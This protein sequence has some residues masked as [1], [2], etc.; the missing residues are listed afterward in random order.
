MN[1]KIAEAKSRL[2]LP[3]LMSQLGLGDHT[4]ELALEYDRRT[5]TRCGVRE[6]YNESLTMTWCE[7]CLWDLVAD[8]QE[9]L[10]P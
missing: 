9:E 6:V 1:D 8:D 5:C 3:R 7:E 4:P 2:P 10:E